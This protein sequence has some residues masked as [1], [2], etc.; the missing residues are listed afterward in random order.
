MKISQR[1]QSYK[2][3]DVPYKFSLVTEIYTTILSKCCCKRNCVWWMFCRIRNV[4]RVHTLC[5]RMFHKARLRI[6]RVQ[7][8]KAAEFS[9]DSVEIFCDIVILFIYD[10]I[11]ALFQN[12][13][14][15]FFIIFHSD[16]IQC[17]TQK[18]PQIS[19]HKLVKIYTKINMQVL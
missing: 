2:L 12:D 8:W 19:K 16:Y 9:F 3:N 13:S 7:F 11:Q 5:V 18:Q 15:Y 1:N 4:P 10:N 14:I 17:I 6:W